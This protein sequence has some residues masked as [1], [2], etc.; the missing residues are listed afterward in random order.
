MRDTP[1]PDASTIGLILIAAFLIAG[2]FASL[3]CTPAMKAL[4]S[5]VGLWALEKAE[6]Y[7]QC[8]IDEVNRTEDFTREEAIECLGP[9]A[10]HRGTPECDEV[11]TWIE[12]HP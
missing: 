7:G 10:P 4:G 1:T 3:G 5:K 8:V 6:R 2:L 12:A 11:R 9:Y